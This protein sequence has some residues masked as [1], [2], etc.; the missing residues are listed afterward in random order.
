MRW[1]GFH[2]AHPPRWRSLQLAVGVLASLAVSTAASQSGVVTSPESSAPA[3]ASVPLPAV[4]QISS[5]P[6]SSPQIGQ[7]STE[8]E[9]AA[10]G[11]GKT[12]VAA[13]QVG[14]YGSGPGS[15]AIGW[16]TSSDGG[17]GWTHG[18][19][20]ALTTATTPA[21]PYP[22]AADPSVAY[23]VATGTWM[24]AAVA[25]VPSGGGYTEG[26]LTVSRSAD[27]RSWSNP[28]VA[29][30]SNQPDKSWI[31]CD[32]DSASQYRGRC[33]LAWSA[34]AAGDSL[35]IAISDDGGSNWSAPI[36][37]SAVGYYNVQPVVRP[38]GTVVVVATDITNGSLAASRSLDGGA[39][40]SPP[41]LVSSVTAH[42]P[43]GGLRENVKPTATVSAD[44]T[45]YIAWADCRFRVGC[46]SNDI[47]ITSSLDGVTWTTPRPLPLNDPT[48]SADHFF[49]G[50]A[51]D[52]SASTPTTRLGL[53][54]YSYPTAA[55]GTTGAPACQLDVSVTD[56][57]DGGTTWSAPIQ[58]DATSMS[59]S[60]LP[61]ATRGR[62]VGDY[63]APAYV[64]GNL[65][66]VVSI[67][68]TLRSK[69]PRYTESMR[70]A[71]V[72]PNTVYVGDVTLTEGNSGTSM[73][74]V[75]V[76]LGAAQST[77]VT[78]TYT[79]SN[80]SAIA[81]SDY[82]KT[83]GTLTIPAGATAATINVPVVGDTIVEPN[84][85]YYVS[86]TAATPV[87]VARA[88]ATV[89]IFNDD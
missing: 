84:E 15:A 14:K 51:A 35:D 38:D 3:A 57:Q 46:P 11:Y 13:F 69:G 8:V 66:P 47:V 41:G 56:S 55:C 4:V 6:F 28:V 77:D 74:S 21:G 9:P 67:A 89:T 50:L 36:A 19:L 53:V 25:V 86:L 30:A 83:T 85:V 43:A 78:I 42:Q 63:F 52:P 5:D 31:A 32:N 61:T 81:G 87:T 72:G 10:A 75:P 1:P 60:W 37:V 49:P 76:Q 64:N 58:L 17:A 39:T 29:V 59:L 45:A 82:L 68:G 79:T 33:Y 88:R 48:A 24:V 65:V 12:V 40:W 16:A 20:P 70:A 54:Y 7:H 18:L 2:R 73:A 62:M 34:G 44:G 80:G 71:V 22:R 26:A 23:D 27:G